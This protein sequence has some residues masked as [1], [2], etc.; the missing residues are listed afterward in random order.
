MQPWWIHSN[1]LQQRSLQIH[2]L[3]Q[4]STLRLKLLYKSPEEYLRSLDRLEGSEIKLAYHSAVLQAWNSKSP[5]RVMWPP[6]L[7][8]MWAG[9]YSGIHALTGGG[10]WT[11]IIYKS[12]SLSRLSALKNGT[13]VPK[14]KLLH[15][16]PQAIPEQV[17]S[18]HK[19]LAERLHLSLPKPWA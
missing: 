15:E 12:S 17:G 7:S 4:N 14:N 11:V 16:E 19:H 2:L 13:K 3:L 6:H 18:P 5:G 9:C 10:W 1:Q 8:A